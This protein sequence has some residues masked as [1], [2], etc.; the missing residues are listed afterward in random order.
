MLYTIVFLIY[1]KRKKLIVSL[2]PNL[3]VWLTIMVAT[4][5]GFSLR[6]VFSIVLSFPLYLICLSNNG[7]NLEKDCKD[8]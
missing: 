2:M 3:L 8:N 4:P 7:M 5:I 1:K 6:Y